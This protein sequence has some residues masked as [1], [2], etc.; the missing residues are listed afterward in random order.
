MFPEL[1]EGSF[2]LTAIRTMFLRI[3]STL[4]LH[5]STKLPSSLGEQNVWLP[6]RGSRVATLYYSHLSSLIQRSTGMKESLGLQLSL[7]SPKGF[8]LFLSVT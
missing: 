1:T 8:E 3:W 7:P 6:D 2:T 4:V 5:L